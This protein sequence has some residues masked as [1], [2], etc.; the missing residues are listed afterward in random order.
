MYFASQMNEPHAT[1]C[2]VS[3]AL[4][5]EICI[6]RARVATLRIELANSRDHDQSA[7]GV[8]DLQNMQ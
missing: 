8:C 6:L 1:A 3:G 7:C 4:S 5:R 2:S